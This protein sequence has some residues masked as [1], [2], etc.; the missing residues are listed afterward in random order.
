MRIQPAKAR[1]STAL[2]HDDSTVAPGQPGLEMRFHV[3]K[4]M[5]CAKHACE[6]R[7]GR[8][9]LDERMHARELAIDY[10]LVLRRPQV[11]RER[12]LGLAQNARKFLGAF[13]IDH[14]AESGLVYHA[15]LERPDSADD[16]REPS[17]EAHGAYL[18]SSASATS[19]AS[20]SP[21]AASIASS[22]QS[23][24]RPLARSMK[25]PVS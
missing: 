23:I 3:V 18:P 16:V 19:G 5:T 17:I 2:L 4:V 8:D 10:L 1:Y 14:P 9:A 6:D 12:V 11:A 13:G 7:I 25:P 15:V 20:S 24:S 22:E 21:L